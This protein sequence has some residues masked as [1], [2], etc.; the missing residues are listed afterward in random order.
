MESVSEEVPDAERHAVVLTA[1]DNI[2]GKWGHSRLND[3]NNGIKFL[4]GEKV[5]STKHCQDGVVCF[6]QKA[7][8]IYS[9]FPPVCGEWMRSMIMN[10]VDAVFNTYKSEEAL[11]LVTGIATKLA[12]IS[13]K[14]T[15]CPDKNELS[16]KYGFCAGLFGQIVVCLKKNHSDMIAPLRSFA[17]KNGLFA[18][19][20]TEKGKDKT[21]SFITDCGF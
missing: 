12:N 11:S 9:D 13:S 8:L 17:D 14:M 2:I 1:I 18:L 15:E 10:I 7:P 5:L 20:L 3:V 21:G 16:V 19:L 4:I 6:L